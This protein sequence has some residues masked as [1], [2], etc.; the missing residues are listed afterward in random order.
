MANNQINKWALPL[1]VAVLLAAWLIILFYR[2]F[3]DPD[4]GRYSEIP[5]EMVSGGNW[6]EMR[7][8]GLRYYEKPP[9]AYWL[10]APAI[11]VFGA[12]D[13]AVRIPLFFSGLLG[14]ALLWSIAVKK[15]GRAHGAAAVLVMVSMIG[16]MAGNGLLLTD[17]F[18]LFFFAATCVFLYLAF[19][20]Q[21]SPSRRL[22]FMLLGAVAAVL[23]FLTKGAVA[24]VLPA[25]I[26]FIWVLWE[27]RPKA[28]FGFPVFL[29]II[30]LAALLLPVMW[31]IEEHNPGFARH[32]IFEEHIARFQGTRATQLHPE[33]FWFFLGVLPLL[34]LPWT[35]FLIRAGRNIWKQKVFGQD[36]FSRFLFVWAAV[37]IVFFSAATGKLMSY[38]LPAIPPLG[39]LIGRWGVSAPREGRGTLDYRLWQTGLAG[40]FIVAAAIVIVWIVAYFRFIP[41]VIYPI[42]GVS[43]VALIPVVAAVIYIYRQRSDIDF[44]KALL[45]NSGILLSCAF[46]LSPLAGKDFNVLLHINSSYVYKSLAREL[47]PEDKIVVFWSY[48]PALAFYAQRHCVHFQEHNELSYGMKMEPERQADLNDAAELAR[49]VENCSGRVFALVEPQDLKSK[50]PAL[51]IKINETDLPRD[52]DTI[53][54][55]LPRSE[56]NKE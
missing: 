14:L 8:M 52:P 37:V 12:H 4:E 16:F 47:K 3:N 49:F 35:L 42:S 21:A 54:Y 17:S 25:A 28:L 26:I 53:I 13:W 56:T 51:K 41:K 6:M 32:F 2:G 46:L 50:F 19:D 45:F 55:E 20:P 9:L 34:C 23:G 24:I 40:F 1:A 22:S 11:K 18:L 36:S 33:P 44:G 7:M 5:R 31:L 38:I 27:R 29:T 48:R 30:C 15:M 39:L 10:V 43:V